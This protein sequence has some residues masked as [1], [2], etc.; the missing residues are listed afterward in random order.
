MVSGNCRASG[1]DSWVNKDE[2]LWF[3]NYRAMTEE[4]NQDLYESR[5]GN[6]ACLPDSRGGC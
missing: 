2:G 3:C 6:G 1:M 5:L 4:D